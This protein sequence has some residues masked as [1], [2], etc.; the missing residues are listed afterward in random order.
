MTGTIYVNG[1]PLTNTQE[2]EVATKVTELEAEIKTQSAYK[3]LEN[4]YITKSQEGKTCINGTKVTDALLEEYKLKVEM[5]KAYILD[6]ST[7]DKL[8]LEADLV[9]KTVQELANLILQLNDSYKASY[10]RYKM[11]LGAFRVKVKALITN[12][13]VDTALEILE[14]AKNINLTTTEAEVAALFI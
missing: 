14:N 13:Q 11:M 6:G 10:N 1:E 12:G 2:S 5:A 3:A 7:A 4:F 9:G 8:Q